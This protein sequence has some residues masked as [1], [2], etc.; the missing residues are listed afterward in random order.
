MNFEFLPLI[1]S[2]YAMWVILTLMTAVSAT[3]F[4]VFWRKRYLAR[5]GR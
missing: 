5:A 1:H 4:L 3:V 2:D